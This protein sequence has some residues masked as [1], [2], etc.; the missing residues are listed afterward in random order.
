MYT[1]PWV[2]M[3]KIHYCAGLNFFFF[4]FFCCFKFVPDLIYIYFFI[5]VLICTHCQSSHVWTEWQQEPP[6][7]E[8]LTQHWLLVLCS[9]SDNRDPKPVLYRNILV[10]FEKKKKKN[11]EGSSTNTLGGAI[12]EIWIFM[13]INLSIAIVLF[14]SDLVFFHSK[15]K[16][17]S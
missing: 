14:K 5:C 1:P 7:E 8:V 16:S 9:S 11:R 4:F 17:T 3:L 15:N 12:N 13:S 6:T 2:R 10:T